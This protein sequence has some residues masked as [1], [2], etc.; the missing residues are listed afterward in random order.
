V[1]NNTVVN[2]TV[3]IQLDAGSSSA[4]LLNNLLSG[5]NNASLVVNNGAQQWYRGNGNL[6]SPSNGTAARI[7][8]TSYTTAQVRNKS[9]AQAWYIH[10][11]NDASDPIQ[12]R[13]AHTAEANSMAFAPTFVDA[14][15]GDFRLAANLGNAIDAGADRTFQRPVIPP[16]SDAQA[17]HVRSAMLSMW[18][19]TKP[20]LRLTRPSRWIRITPRALEFSKTMALSSEPCSPANAAPQDRTSCSGMASTIITSHADRHLH[21]QDDRAQRAVRMQNVVG[22][23]SVPNSGECVHNGFE[24]IKAMTFSG[25]T[26]FYTSGY[27]E[28]HYELN[29]FD[30]SNPNRLT[31]IFG[32]K[33]FDPDAITDVASDGASVFAM[34]SGIVSIYNQNDLDAQPRTIN[35]GG[36]NTHIEAQKNGNLLFVS[37][38][39]LN[40]ISIYDKNTGA[41]TG[42]ISVSQPDDLSVTASGDL[43]VISGTSAIRYSV[44]SSGGSVAQ[45]IGGFGNPIAIACSPVDGTVLV[46]DASA[47]Q[48]K[49]FNASGAASGRMGRAADLPMGRRSRR[50]I[51]LGVLRSGKDLTT[52]FLQFQ[53]DG[54]WWVGDTYL[55]RSLHFNMQRSCSTRSIISRTPTWRPWI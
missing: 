12:Y 17:Q 45:T 1:R 47:W 15:A 36:G 52:T 35:A 32:P 33:T 14:L 54:T 20:S 44:T 24:P 46:A 34:D 29:R 50:Q 42:S 48:V 10:D 40:T 53:P 25:T 31:K 2:G 28:N 39:S 41:R 6:Y 11:T 49:A 43:R 13:A 4:T 30:T 51:L 55:S 5:Q 37:K 27:N 7:A 16:V 9:L 26:A 18:A 21:D 38:K 23:S 3:G 8:G 22:N 19:P